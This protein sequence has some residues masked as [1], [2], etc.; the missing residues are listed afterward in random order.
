MSAA[1][2][3]AEKLEAE[4]APN[5]SMYTDE[6]GRYHLIFNPEL[7][8]GES[9]KGNELIVAAR[10]VKIPTTKLKIQ[11]YVVEGR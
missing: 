7:T 9:S 8:V 2:E 5:L 3:T 1:V 11:M 4:L 6:K 10:W